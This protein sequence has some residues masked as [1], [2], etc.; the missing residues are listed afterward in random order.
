MNKLQRSV[1][2]AKNRLFYDRPVYVAGYEYNPWKR[3]FFTALLL[4]LIGIPTVSR[5]F[6][7][8]HYAFPTL[9][10]LLMFASLIA[11]F[12]G[13]LAPVRFSNSMS[14]RAVISRKHILILF[15]LLSVVFFFLTG[16]TAPASASTNTAG[17]PPA[18]RNNSQAKHA[19]TVQT[20][21]ETK[22]IPFQTVTQNSSGLLKG[23]TQVTQQGTDGVETSVYT[24]N[25]TGDKETSR[26]LVSKSVTKEPISKIIS[27]GTYEVSQVSS[28][29]NGGTGY[30]NVDGNYINSPSSDPAGA[31]AQC[32]D[33]TYSYSA[34]RRGTCSHH[35]GV[36]RWL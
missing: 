20:V 8:N 15:G 34:N 5:I 36:A 11:L 19:T 27:V 16:L 17:A 23:Q 21:T 25:L 33:G 14:L 32:R 9:Y 26:T 3:F 24:V 4:L 7:D 6:F 30:T 35:G 22:S 18:I 1:S 12:W 10:M 29:S 31:S 2:K 13:L 28:S